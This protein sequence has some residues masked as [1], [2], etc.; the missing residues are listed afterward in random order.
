MKIQLTG[1]YVFDPVKAFDFYTKTLGFKEQ[2]F[3]PDA[4]LAIVVSPEEPDGTALLLEPSDN[5]IAKEYMGKLY[6]SGLPSIVFSTKDI[7][8]EYEH[9]KNKGVRFTK[10]PTQTDWGY[11]AIFDDTCGNLIQLAQM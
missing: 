10:S 9:L 11:E 4:Q 2:L 5:P 3:V 7:Q 6:E 8:A 1:I